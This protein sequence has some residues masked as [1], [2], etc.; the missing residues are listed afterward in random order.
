MTCEQLRSSDAAA[1]REAS[2]E[3]EET[4][5]QPTLNVSGIAGGVSVLTAVALLW[6]L[7][8]TLFWMVCAW[9]AMRAHERLADSVDELARGRR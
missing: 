2:H 3:K 6:G 1:G 5:M 4:G 8:V 9:R 7:L